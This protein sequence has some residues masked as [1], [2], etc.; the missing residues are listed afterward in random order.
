MGGEQTVESLGQHVLSFFNSYINAH[1]GLMYVIEGHP[2]RLAASYAISAGCSPPTNVMANA[3][4]VGQAL[5]DRK[6][7]RLEQVSLRLP[8]RRFFLGQMTPRDVI[9]APIITDG[10]V[11]GVIELAFASRTFATD[12]ELLE[13]LSPAIGVASRRATT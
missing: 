4:L 7:F 3:G 10:I 5:V 1:A 8:A 11:L 6:T 13:R 9:V 12:V 2:L